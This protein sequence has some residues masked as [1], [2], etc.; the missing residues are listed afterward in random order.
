M[1]RKV[2]SK[3]WKAHG[4]AGRSG[5]QKLD[6]KLDVSRT[7]SGQ[8]QDAG[9]MGTGVLFC[10]MMRVL[11]VLHAAVCMTHFFHPLRLLLSHDAL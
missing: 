5:T 4:E 7:L 2:C 9:P 10:P 1:R 6:K 8:R 11:P 3:R